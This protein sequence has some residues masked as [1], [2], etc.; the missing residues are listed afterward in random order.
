M[1]KSETYSMRIINNRNMVSAR[2]LT[3][4]GGYYSEDSSDTHASPT[5]LISFANMKGKRQSSS[6]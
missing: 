5:L 6:R 1:E 2:R 4:Y 3:C